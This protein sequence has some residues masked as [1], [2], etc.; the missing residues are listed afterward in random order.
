[1]RP[2]RPLWDFAFEGGSR[3]TYV[4]SSASVPLSVIGVESLL[5]VGNGRSWL[6]ALSWRIGTELGLLRMES[7]GSRISCAC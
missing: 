3:F 1:M 2:R 6:L 5:K 7:E 4:S